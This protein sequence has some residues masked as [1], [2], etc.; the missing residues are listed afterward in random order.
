MA[1]PTFF[2]VASNPADNGA[3]NE[4]TTLAVTPPASMVTGDLVVLI[5]WQRSTS[6]ASMT[7]SADGGQK[8]ETTVGVAQNTSSAKVFW[9]QFDGVWTADPSI[10]FAA[11][12]GTITSH[13]AMLVF[14][15]ANPIGAVWTLCNAFLGAAEASASP[16]V[17]T[18]ITPARPD[19]VTLAMWL[20]T[21]I[22]TWGTLSGVGWSKTGLTAQ[23]RNT[24]GSDTSASFAYQLQGVAAPTNDVSQVPSTA[25]TGCSFTMAWA[26]APIND[27]TIAPDTDHVEDAY[28]AVAY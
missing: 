6:L 25:T 26:S 23:Y 27:R 3:A 24:G 21:N 11:Q 22:S 18:G 16:V 7:L 9:C 28:E 10:A 1:A 5:G 4:P 12:G 15:S 14:R 8:W 20:I 17:I 13:V 2:G 19:N